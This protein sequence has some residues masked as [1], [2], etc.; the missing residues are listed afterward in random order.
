[1]VNYIALEN[2]ESNTGVLVRFTTTDSSKIKSSKTVFTNKM[3]LY[4]KLRPYLN[5]VLLPS[6]VGIC[7][8]DIL[9]LAPKSNIDREF[10]AYFLRSWHVLSNVKKS[11]HGTKMP[12]IP[13][14]GVMFWYSDQCFLLREITSI[15]ILN[16]L[17]VG[18]IQFVRTN[19]LFVGQICS[20]K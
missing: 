17:F 12:H 16:L 15:A 3:V 19:S 1:M 13:Q 14:L 8:T 10:L 9:P 5:K 2:I 11:M 4:G 6:F 7:S 20:N 18:E